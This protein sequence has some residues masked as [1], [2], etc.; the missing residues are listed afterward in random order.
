MSLSW[1]GRSA[2]VLS[3]GL[4]CLLSVAGC[5]SDGDAITPS[6]APP[7]AQKSAAG[8]QSRPWHPAEPIALP[9]P[10]SDLEKEQLRGDYLD[11]LATM[12][13]MSDS[14][15]VALVRWTTLDTVNSVWAKCYT[16][17]GFPARPSSDGLGID[18]I[19]GIEAAQERAFSRVEY[20]CNAKYT[21]DPKYTRKLTNDQAGL[22]YD[23][24][25]QSFVPCL[26]DRGVS[27]TDPPAKGAFVAGFP[28]AWDPVAQASELGELAKDCPARPPA[29]DLY[30]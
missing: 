24:Y 30:G 16:E 14:P 2:L 7:P 23:Y 19:G 10:L 5:T 6:S 1:I 17:G 11:S 20:A 15:G 18:H 21:I 4:A 25:V 29:S 13:E 8:Q 28:S 26:R 27:I 12:N 22:V 9:A 3:I